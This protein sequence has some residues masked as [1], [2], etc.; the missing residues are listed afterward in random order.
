VQNQT[1]QSLQAIVDAAASSSDF[2]GAVRISLGPGVVVEA[3]Y[4][5][6]DRSSRLTNRVDTRFGIASGT[7]LFT[8]LGV[9]VLLDDG[10]L[11]LDDHVT[12]V[13]RHRLPNVSREVT[14][15]QLLTHT[16]GVFDYYDEEAHQDFDDFELAIPPF[17]LVELSDYLPLLTEGEMKFAPGSRFSYSNGG[18]VL[19]GLAIEGA[20]G[21]PYHQF[22]EEAVLRPCRMTSSGFFRFDRLPERVATGYIEQD[23]QWRSNVYN[24]PII[25]GPDG[26]MF[27]TV[28]DIESMWRAVLDGTLLTP[29]LARRYQTASA[30]F[31]DNVHYGMGLWIRDDGTNRRRIYIEGCDAGASFQSTRYADGTIATVMSNTT[32]GAWPVVE[33]ID[34]PLNQHAET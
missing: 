16:S 5:Y 21:T 34:D 6:A 32:E 29:A 3:A 11:H 4:G 7:K 2:S 30:K 19:L 17:K 15:G 9:G 1:E 24:L 27:S 14:V 18:Y 13:V 31:K 12:D 20:S 8:A 26:G 28:G 10:V 25:G 33:A 23:G 22:I